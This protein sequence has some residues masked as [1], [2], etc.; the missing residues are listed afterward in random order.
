MAIPTASLAQPT[1]WASDATLWA[2]ELVMICRDRITAL[3]NCSCAGV[4]GH[5]RH[6]CFFMELFKVTQT[7]SAL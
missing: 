6:L 2:N 1:T 7:R 5:H 3:V 4:K